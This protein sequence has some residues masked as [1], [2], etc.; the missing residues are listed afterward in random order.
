VTVIAGSGVTDETVAVFARN[1]CVVEVH[2]GR[3]AR[4]GGDPEAPVSASRVRRLR[5]LADGA[6]A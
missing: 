3:A 4:E 5:A 1:A 6:G 2:V